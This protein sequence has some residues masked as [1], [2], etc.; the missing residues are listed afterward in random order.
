MKIKAVFSDFSHRFAEKEIHVDSKEPINTFIDEKNPQQTI[1]GFG[2]AI[3][4]SSAA[5]YESLSNENK[6][7]VIDLLYGEDGLRYN[8]GRLTIGSC[9][10]SPV[11]YDYS[12]K[13]DLS[14]FDL[15]YDKQHI[16]PFLRD[17]FFKKKLNL[18]ASCWSP[19]AKWKT[20]NDKCHGGKLK[21][22]C[23]E[24]HADYIAH[25]CQ[26]MEKLGYPISALTIQNEPEATQTW[27]SCRFDEKE[28]GRMVL[29]LH[30]LLPSTHLYVWDH[31]RDVM[32]RRI[33]N[34]FKDPAV[35]Q[36]TY[37]VAY[38]WYDGDKN[39]EIARCRE[40]YPSKEFLFTE[41]CIEILNLPKGY[42]N[43]EKA[44]WASALRYARNYLLDL[45]YGS[46]GFV[47]WNVLL[48]E[49]G[50]PNHVGNYCKAPLMRNGDA[51]KINPSYYAIKH[52]SAF[53]DP[54]CS[55]IPVKSEKGLLCVAAMNPDGS[56][57][58]VAFNEKSKE[59]H[60]CFSWKNQNYSFDV[61]KDEI[62]SLR[63]K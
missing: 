52:L 49:K 35:E 9:D 48:D 36:A 28:E 22:D 59:N 30:E 40:K 56:L 34:L 27:E 16:L 54:G 37:G 50:G 17:A 10:F 24:K 15:A 38:H 11:L 14:D 53:L 60:L 12:S 5:V 57:S 39:K 46:N 18:L 63:I 7:K 47:D 23:Y 58:F 2:G 3:T 1:K 4:A 55:M 61:Q 43:N 62:V 31:N 45:Q 13:D 26:E 51:I 41:G 6:Q 19:L 32:F 21:S 20:N 33:Q 8:L 44:I 42:L 25:Y 29:L